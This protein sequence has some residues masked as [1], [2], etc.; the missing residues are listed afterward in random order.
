[1]APTKYTQSLLQVGGFWSGIFAIPLCVSLFWYVLSHWG[2]WRLRN[3]GT[4][5]PLVRTWHG[6]VECG[7]KKK[8]RERNRLKKSPSKMLPRSTRADYGWVFWDP[9]GA[10]QERFNKKKEET[11]LRYLPQWMRSSPFGS[12]EPENKTG[13][14]IEAARGSDAIESDHT[15]TTGYLETLALL[16]RGWRRGWR[17]ARKWT[18]SSE[19]SQDTQP[20]PPNQEFTYIPLSGAQT[21]HE[22]I[23]TVRMR[24]LS[25]RRSGW[26]A[27]SEDVQ[28]ATNTQL[29]APT[30]G[31]N[32]ANL[33]RRGS[34]QEQV[35]DDG[36]LREISHNPCERAEVGS[37]ISQ[38][39]PVGCPW[40]DLK[41]SNRLRNITAPNHP[42]PRT[43]STGGKELN[44]RV[45]PQSETKNL[46]MRRRD[47]VAGPNPSRRIQTWT[48]GVENSLP[49]S[50]PTSSCVGVPAGG[51]EP[52]LRSSGPDA[53][54]A[55]VPRTREGRWG[56]DDEM[57][58]AERMSLIDVKRLGD[59]GGYD[60]VVGSGE[61]EG[62]DD[63]GSDG[64]SLDSSF[65]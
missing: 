30:A 14:D 44:G 63:D 5:A 33:F 28:R 27:D 59:M 9:T 3:R 1:M 55:A 37:T 21:L 35:A 52:V 18:E 41:S 15:S 47:G 40:H 26:E 24:K 38:H 57:A 53:F 10:R 34:D 51:D 13:Q 20:H 17:R 19:S 61:G 32:L 31:S 64:I 29:L 54:H 42:P 36:S 23:T 58:E 2:W 6:W 43:L 48:C 39:H 4:R 7:P 11:I 62:D 12:A 16:G 8:K 49:K 45:S 46:P 25:R 65:S 22:D 56:T 60:G 50:V